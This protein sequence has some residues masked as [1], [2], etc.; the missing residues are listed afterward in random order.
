MSGMALALLHPTSFLLA[1][2][3]GWQNVPSKVNTGFLDNAQN[4]CAGLPPAKQGRQ[5]HITARGWTATGLDKLGASLG[6][7]Q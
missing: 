2:Q 1:P 6:K 5:D 4:P 3:P 7:L